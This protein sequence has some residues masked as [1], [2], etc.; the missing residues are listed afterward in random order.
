MQIQSNKPS[1]HYFFHRA[2]RPFFLGAML[3]SAVSMFIWW[4][5]FTGT[6]FGF[7]TIPAMYWHAHEMV[8]GYAL[9]TV[10]GFL[11]TAVM[12]WSKLN[13]ASGKLLATVFVLWLLARL[14]FIFDLP[15]IW[16]MLFDMGF[17]LGVCLHFTLPII[18]TK[19]WQQAGL[20]AKFVLLVIANAV[21]YLGAFGYIENGVH[22]GTLLGLFLVLAINLTMMRRLIPFFTEK[23]LAKP[24]QPQSKFL[25]TLAIVG[26][27]ALM[28]CASFYPV[29]L[30]TAG[31]GLLLFV[32]HGIRF[33]KWFEPAI[34]KF[35]VLWPL[36]LSYLFMIIGMGLY[37]FV[38]LGLVNESIAIHA[39]AAGG[40]G[41]LCSAILSRIALGHSNRNIYEPPKGLNVVFALLVITAVIRV[42]M[43]IILPEQLFLWTTMAQWGWLLAFTILSVMYWKILV[44]PSPKP[45]TGVLL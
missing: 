2:F 11:L 17:V 14:G 38:G 42:L 44:Y 9:A 34:F 3:F 1:Q 13:S 43:P 37:L 31:L 10:T 23:T 26:F 21:F 20:M 8:F 6:Q 36:H 4:L 28:M 22:I 32:V 16:V 30:F 24:E 41:L 40:I 45:Q 12:N 35:T 15:L 7:S 5:S 25:D 27:L 29:S 18:K 19:Q 33:I 39:L